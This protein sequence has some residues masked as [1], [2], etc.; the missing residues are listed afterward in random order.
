MIPR[1]VKWQL[2]L[3]Y[4]AIALLATLSL[5]LVLLITLRGYYAQRE[6]DYLI[7]NAQ[8]I[9][10]TIIPLIAEE[11]PPEVLELQL[12]NLS[13]LSQTRVRLLD[14]GGKL[15][16]E[17]GAPGAS[18]VSLGA[19]P[20][21]G[22]LAEGVDSTE[23][24]FRSLIIVRD[25]ADYASATGRGTISPPVSFEGRV[26]LEDLSDGRAVFF[27]RTMPIL[28]TPYGFGLNTDS[29][30][31]GQRSGQAVREP[32]TGTAGDLLGYVELS[33]GPAYGRQ[34]LNS[35]ARGWA[36]AGG[37]AV[38][39]AAGVGWVVSRY[40]NAPLLSITSVTARMAEGDLSART[41]VVRQDE[42]GTLAHSFNR[43]AD[44]LEET[45]LTLRRF[46]SD[47]AH[48]IHTPLT[49]LHTNLE[50]APPNEFV[51]QAQ[52]QVERLESL[53]KGLLDLSRIKAHTQEIRAPVSL[54]PLVQGTAEAYA[55]QAEQAGL[56]FD[57][58]LP[59]TPVSVWG[60]E[61]QLQRVLSNLLDN[62]IKFTAED[63]VVRVGLCQ[64]GEW[65]K[66]WVE[67]SGIG[68]P[69]EDLPLLFSRF[70]RGRNAAA[71]PGSGLGL[72]IVEAVV[73]SHGG[74]VTVENLACGARFTV[75]LPRCVKRESRFTHHD[76]KVMGVT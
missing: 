46:V 36:L 30:S 61:T 62:A 9:S 17:S 3:S 76:S 31:N 48:E 35:V 10:A 32:L 29:S 7:G 6:R 52:A 8:A 34:I 18:R 28:G 21:S 68:V 19:V 38:L 73:E 55:S 51:I 69:V 59:E 70:H 14:V 37:V 22:P 20:I 11:A 13:F 12:S 57:L 44:R 41:N 56:G 50:L 60:D 49:A 24:S 47:A 33:E 65:V 71:Y 42:F 43:M 54:I 25:V 75:R 63:G 67:D 58:I 74:R 64:V 66:L 40:I 27:I 16:A 53:T 23:P 45:V 1:S 26:G 2:P 39:V 5:G 4:A 15:V 72:A